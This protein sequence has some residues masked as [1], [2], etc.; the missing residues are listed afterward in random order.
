MKNTKVKIVVFQQFSGGAD[1]IINTGNLQRHG[2]ERGLGKICNHDGQRRLI[3]VFL[4]RR[5]ET[6]TDGTYPMINARPMLECN[7]DSVEFRG[8][9]IGRVDKTEISFF[10]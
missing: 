8:D 2:S 9:R 7:Q 4:P 3:I 5:A 10:W 6:H 1:K